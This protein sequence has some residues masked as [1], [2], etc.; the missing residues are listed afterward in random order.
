MQN[1]DFY[2]SKYEN[3]IVIEILKLKWLMTLEDFVSH[4]ILTIW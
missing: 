1:H 4:T 3:F 2:S